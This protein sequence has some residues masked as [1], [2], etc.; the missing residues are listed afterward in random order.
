MMSKVDF[1][2]ISP[3]TL[4]HFAVA[5]LW[6]LEWEDEERSGK[7]GDS[8]GMGARRAGV[9]VGIESK[10]RADPAAATAALPFDGRLFSGQTWCVPAAM[11]VPVAS[12]CLLLA[13]SCVVV[14]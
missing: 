7:D 8:Y 2:S 12:S 9:R 5:C 1:A 11:A 10:H 14:V 3:P 6:W 4:A 13:Q